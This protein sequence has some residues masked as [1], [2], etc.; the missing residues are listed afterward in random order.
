MPTSPPPPLPALGCCTALRVH[1]TGQG[2]Y[3]DVIRYA[4][5]LFRK[6]RQAVAQQMAP[7]TLKAAF[8]D[9]VHE[10]LAVEVQ[11]ELFA[12]TDGEFMAMFNGGAGQGGGGLGAK[13]GG[14]RW[15]PACKCRNGGGGTGRSV[16]IAGAAWR[17]AGWWR[18]GGGCWGLVWLL[19]RGGPCWREAIEQGWWLISR[20]SGRPAV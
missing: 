10:R 12:R 11:V 1:V 20:P 14:R 5:H 3:D 19:R 2:T 7:S 13:L 18:L 4:E 16:D 9:P 15:L 17:V 6:I 8:L